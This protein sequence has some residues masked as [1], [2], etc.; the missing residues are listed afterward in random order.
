MAGMRTVQL[1]KVF[2][3][4]YTLKRENPHA[5]VSDLQKIHTYFYMPEKYNYTHFLPSSDRTLHVDEVSAT[6]PTSLVILQVGTVNTI[7][8]S[9]RCWPS[10]LKGCMDLQW[11][12]INTNIHCN[13]KRE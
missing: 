3:K 6:F 5:I 9:C 11:S 13:R 1:L 4:Y 10:V 7:G 12:K 8:P 2:M